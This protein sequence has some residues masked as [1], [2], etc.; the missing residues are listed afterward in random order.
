M[1]LH[2]ISTGIEPE[3]FAK[4][5]LCYLR[6]WGLAP[7]FIDDTDLWAY[8]HD[9][10]DQLV[11]SESEAVILMSNDSAILTWLAERPRVDFYWYQCLSPEIHKLASTIERQNQILAL[12]GHFLHLLSPSMFPNTPLPS[13][14][15]LPAPTANSP[16]PIVQMSSRSVY[17]RTK[18]NLV[19]NLEGVFDRLHQIHGKRAEH[20]RIK[21]ES[22]PDPLDS[23]ERLMSPNCND[24]CI[25]SV[26]DSATCNF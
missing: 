8:I 16:N 22:I 17:P 7:Q 20:S 23:I 3:Y 14:I 15:Y 13:S 11:I 6:S 10:A 4:L 18:S 9:R 2:F 26:E 5:L 21:F 24:T 1:A 25:E 12:D 19:K